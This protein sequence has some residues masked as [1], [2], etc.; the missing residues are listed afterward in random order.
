MWV[1][2]KDDDSVLKEEV[3]FGVLDLCKVFCGSGVLDVLKCRA[4]F[5]AVGTNGGNARGKDNVYEV[6]R[7]IER[8]RIEGDDGFGNGVFGTCLC[9]GILR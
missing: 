2:A 1:S 3:V 6:L 7:G 5:K 4:A 9:R 8:V